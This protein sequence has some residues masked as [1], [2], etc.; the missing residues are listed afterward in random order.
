MLRLLRYFALSLALLPVGCGIFGGLR[1]EPVATSVQR[2]SNVAVYLSVADGSEPV[3]DLRLDN[4][5]IF[6]N[7][8]PVP[9][10]DAKLTLLDRNVAAVHHT[11]LL[12][13]MSGALDDQARKSLVNG[14]AGF[15]DKLRPQQGVTVYAFDGSAALTAIGEFP[16]DGQA[17]DEDALEKLEK[18]EPKDPS[19]NLHGA[20]LEGLKELDARLMS[21]KKPVRVGS[22]VIFTRGPDLAGRTTE[23]EVWNELDESGHDV[24]TVGIGGEG[25]QYLDKWG[26]SGAVR[27]QTAHTVA[28]AFEEAA[29]KVD[30]AYDRFYLLSYCSPA[31]AGMRHLRVE[32]TFTTAEGEEK[33]GS[34]EQDFD[35]SGFGPGCDPNTPP[36]FVTGAADASS[37]EQPSEP[38]PAEP[39]ADEKKERERGTNGGS[40][41]G[42]PADDAIV[43]PPSHKTYDP[44]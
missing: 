23:D 36:R 28:I 20:M 22:L 18:F 43:E 8:Q 14:V 27:S 15:V 6:E 11:L 2:P 26:R 25:D 41:P 24:F 19:R 33:K 13:D 10:A 35:A 12:V 42:K 21:V 30:A 3:G 9:T 16:R 17:A 38:E 29:T 34:L 1:V 40:A 4:F 44:K 37:T 32:V 7:E 5:A 39:K 31:R